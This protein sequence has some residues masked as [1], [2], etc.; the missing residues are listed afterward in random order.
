MEKPNDA[1]FSPVT[2]FRAVTNVF[3][4]CGERDISNPEF[5][6]P[7]LSKRLRVIDDDFKFMRRDTGVIDDGIECGGYLRERL[8]LKIDLGNDRAL[9]K[10]HRFFDGG[11]RVLDSYFRFR[12]GSIGGRGFRCGG[13]RADM[14][15]FPLVIRLMCAGV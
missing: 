4:E 9:E 5:S 1:R 2:E 3:Q 8:I 13:F 14:R 12:P 6:D 15:T 7:P 10:L 11:L